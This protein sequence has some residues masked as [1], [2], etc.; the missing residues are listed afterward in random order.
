MPTQSV[1]TVLI[2]AIVGNLLLMLFLV[3]TLSGRRRARSEKGVDS[4]GLDRTP[5]AAHTRASLRARPVVGSSA[6][7]GSE[8]AAIGD[9][10]LDPLTG[11]DGR[12]A[13]EH[14]VRDEDARHERY[15][16]PLAV[17]V[18]E[19][20][21]LSR[22]S[23]RFGTGPEERIVRAVGDALERN[24]RGSDKVARV[25]QARF[26]VLLAET[27]EIAAINYVE[28]VRLACDRWLES[29]A[30]ALRLSLG[31]ASPAGG[32]NIATALHVAEDRLLAERRQAGSG[33]PR[34][35]TV[36][37]LQEAGPAG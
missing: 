5:G 26:H 12:L 23:E 27:D 24:A 36:T 28:R 31:W 4:I 6:N 20:D 29:G 25:D 32:G 35:R 2:V 34:A 1:V 17:V 9:G 10:W 11:L 7:N 21:G 13:W 14:A 22:L 30:V 15:R 33:T 18:V 8:P 16:R 37:P 19:L 3:A